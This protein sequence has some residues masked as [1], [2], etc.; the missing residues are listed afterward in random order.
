MSREQGSELNQDQSEWEQAGVN[1]ADAAP[2]E[3]V[4]STRTG[5]RMATPTA[6][7]E[8]F[9][10]N[11]L[12]KGR[13]IQNASGAARLYVLY[14]DMSGSGALDASSTRFTALL[15]PGQIWEPLTKFVGK[16]YGI[17]GAG[18]VAGDF[19]ACTELM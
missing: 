11:S 1:E 10:G 12:S 13:I 18:S 14:G 15:L 17:W 4:R 16:I 6:I 19:V 7:T 3:V 5:N 2:V 8:L 9:S